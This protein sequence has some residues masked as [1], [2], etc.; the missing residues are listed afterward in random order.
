M[1][2]TPEWMKPI[3]GMESVERSLLRGIS[4]PEGDTNVQLV[5]QLD[6][7]LLDAELTNLIRAQLQRTFSM[8]PAGLLERLRPEVDAALALAL[9]GA[10]IWIQRP[11]PGMRLQNLQYRNERSR[12]PKSPLTVTQ[13]VLYG[14][15][16]VLGK[17]GFERF[18]RHGLSNGWPELPRQD[19]RRKAWDLMHRLRQVVQVIWL[20]N[21]LAFLRY[22]RYPTPIERVLGMRMIHSSTKPGARPINYQF[23]NRQL[24]WDYGS[25][26]AV[27]LVPLVDWGALGRRLQSLVRSRRWRRSTHPN[28]CA[29]CGAEPPT[30]PYVAQ[31][32]HT[33]CFYCLST[34][35]MDDA[36]Y[37]CPACL[38]V[39]T[40]SAPA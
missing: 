7:G 30:S 9:F 34:S 36:A 13:R 19:T 22:G 38:V 27:T 5:S 15:V 32:G 10:T 28:S 35:C 17:A 2:S 14:L 23:I 3:G 24:L 6:S 31:C 18:R 29:V 25:E 39:V 12:H 33:F 4:S 26:M 8:F 16:L 20:V 40:R 1:S 37:R 21:T 11:T